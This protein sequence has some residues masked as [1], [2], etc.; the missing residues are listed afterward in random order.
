MVNKS[1]GD[2]TLTLRESVMK[3][4]VPFVFIAIMCGLLG[5]KVAIAGEAAQTM[6]LIQ[7]S[8]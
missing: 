4:Y 8:Q 6:P 7:T 2:L 1:E 3:K 5:T